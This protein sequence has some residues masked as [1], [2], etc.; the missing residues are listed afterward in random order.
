[1]PLCFMF[2]LFRNLTTAASSHISYLLL[3]RV[4]FGMAG[5]KRSDEYVAS[6]RTFH[7]GKISNV[8]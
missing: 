3:T 4:S 5:A 6:H 1:M 8:Y 7:T 2:G